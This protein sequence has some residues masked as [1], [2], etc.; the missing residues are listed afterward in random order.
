MKRK[1][2]R[3]ED[4]LLEEFLEQKCRIDRKSEISGRHL[5]EAFDAWWMENVSKTR[6]SRKK[7]A[8]LMT[9]RGFEKVK[10]LG[11]LVYRGLQLKKS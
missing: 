8:L 11:E 7:F 10:K 1:A 4:E 5:Y 2:Y 6:R 3:T 9:R